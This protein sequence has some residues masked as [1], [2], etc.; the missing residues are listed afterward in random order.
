MK[1]NNVNLGIAFERLKGILLESERVYHSETPQCKVRAVGMLQG[2]ILNHITEC[3]D[4][5]HTKLYSEFREI[6]SNVQKKDNDPDDI[7]NVNIF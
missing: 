3:T 5:D 1:V 2:G 7:K 6:E 4:A